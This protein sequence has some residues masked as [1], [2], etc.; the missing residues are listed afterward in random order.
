MH[1][2]QSFHPFRNYLQGQNLRDFDNS[3]NYG[4]VLFACGHIFNKG[5]INLKLRNR[6]ALEQR[7]RR[8]ASTKVIYGNNHSQINQFPHYSHTVIYIRQ[9]HALCNLQAKIIRVA[10]SFI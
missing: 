5:F 3:M 7:Q 8:V 9:H 1:L 10:G 4:C 2:L 6:K